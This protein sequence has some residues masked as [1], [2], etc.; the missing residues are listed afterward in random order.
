MAFSIFG[1]LKLKLKESM[2]Y[3]MIIWLSFLQNSLMLFKRQHGPFLSRDIT[4]LLH[5]LWINHV[6][7]V[8]SR[9][10]LLCKCHT[11]AFVQFNAHWSKT[12]PNCS[13]FV[14]VPHL[15]SNS[16]DSFHKFCNRESTKIFNENECNVAIH[17]SCTEDT[18]VL[19]VSVIYFY[20]S[21]S[22]YSVHEN[23]RLRG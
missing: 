2:K 9:A 21:G 15:I 3:I 5:R 4:N 10:L 23:Q 13:R 6:I 19:L 14:S 17:I 16:S 8:T 22:F 11:F 20:R 7:M 1:T 12:E 18:L